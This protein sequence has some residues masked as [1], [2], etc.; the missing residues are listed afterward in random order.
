MRI[1][2]IS[3][4]HID[5]NNVQNEGTV[6]EA[7]GRIVQETG[8]DLLIIAGDVSNNYATT[9]SFLEEMERRS[10][11]DCLF[12]PGNHDLWNIDY[13]EKDAWALYRH[14]Q[15]FKGNI[16]TAPYHINDEWVVVGDVGWY[17][18]SFG[19]DKFAEAR[20]QEMEYNE[21][22]WKDKI[23]ADWGSSAPEVHQFFY[24]KLRNQIKRHK[25]KKIIL[26][27][28]V[29]PHENFIVPTPHPVWDY[30]NAF[31]GSRHYSD[32]ITE[33]PD[34]IKYAIC[35]H[36]HYRKQFQLGE[37]SLICNC[38]G[39]KEEWLHSEEAYE[40]ISHTYLTIEI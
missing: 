37:T 1:G 8:T 13:P 29:V 24:Q 14:L 3:D 26:V 35:G 31:L 9:L 40:E 33:F 30:F 15:E 2:I 10:G 11:V 16:T 27:T 21:R 19:S 5:K 7:L 22:I 38:L 39:D 34:T 17:D 6:Q 12:V 25:D 18:F 36:V 28:H 4:V 32:L 20:F 23:Y